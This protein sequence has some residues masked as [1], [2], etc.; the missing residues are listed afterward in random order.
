MTGTDALDALIR[1]LAQDQLDIPKLGEAICALRGQ[2]QLAVAAM[3]A[4]IADHCD[5]RQ[6][7]KLLLDIAASIALRGARKF[8]R[9]HCIPLPYRP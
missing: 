7:R 8:A 2:D 4:S 5:D 3:V 6:R 1:E 9:T